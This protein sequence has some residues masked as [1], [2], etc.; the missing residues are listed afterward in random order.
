MRPNGTLFFL[1]KRLLQGKRYLEAFKK[2]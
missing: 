1:S 2:S